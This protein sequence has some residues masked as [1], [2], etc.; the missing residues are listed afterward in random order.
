[1]STASFERTSKK[2]LSIIG[3]IHDDK[4]ALEPLLGKENEQRKSNKNLNKLI[5]VTIVCFFF[6]VIEI[7]GGY[8]A[9][10]IA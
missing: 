5:L 3:E 9:S 8:F 10:S 7:I 1:M 4:D 6:M 2:K